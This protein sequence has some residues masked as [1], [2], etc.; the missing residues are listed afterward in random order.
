MRTV[1]QIESIKSKVSK[2]YAV[3]NFISASD[4]AHLITVFEQHKENATEGYT[5]KIHK[6]TGPITLDLKQYI[7]DHVVHTILTKIEEEIGKFEITAAFFFSTDYPHIIHNDDTFELPDSVYKAIT[8]PLRIDGQ[9][10]PKLCFFDQFYFQGPAKFFKGSK[11][12]PTYYNKQIYDYAEVDGIV[13][14]RIEDPD[15]LFTHLRPEWL[16]GLSVHSAIEWK[17][18]TAIIFDSTRLHCASDFRQ[19]GIKSKLGISIFT[20]QID[21]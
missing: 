16:E 1:E 18:T 5:G 13:N 4:V 20:K 12:I 10:I 17:P 19:L 3:D 6:N 2:P 7:D 21:V 14:T 11:D 9:G 15:N 8:V